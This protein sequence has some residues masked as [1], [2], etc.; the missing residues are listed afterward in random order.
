MKNLLKIKQGKYTN[1]DLSKMSMKCLYGVDINEKAVEFSKLMINL[2]VAKW[3]LKNKIKEYANTVKKDSILQK[4]NKDNPKKL[5]TAQGH[6]RKKTNTKKTTKQKGKK[7]LAKNA[8]KNS[9]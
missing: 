3:T 9:S 4:G 5:N 8:K 1:E 2:N 6:V 7:K